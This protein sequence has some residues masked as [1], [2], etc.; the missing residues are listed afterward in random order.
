MNTR[1][2]RNRYRIICSALV[3]LAIGAG[4]HGTIVPAPVQAQ[5]IFDKLRQIISPSTNRGTATGRSRGGAIRGNCTADKDPSGFGYQLVALMPKTNL[6]TTVEANP[7]FW[8]YI[9]PFRYLPSNT[10][11][12]PQLIQVKAGEFMLLDDKGKP[13]LKRPIPVKLSDQAGFARFTLPKDPAFWVGSKSLEVGKR[14]NWFF[15][16]ACDND[17]PARNPTVSGWVQRV[18]QPRNLQQQLKQIAPRDRYTVYLQNDNWYESITA[19][20]DNRQT[21]SDAWLEL[22]KQLDLTKVANAPIS[23]MEPVKPR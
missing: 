19:L 13:M 17:Q 21:A 15:S 16:I 5:S 8:F 1:V 18:E 23:V 12:S 4:I 7:T 9:P 11:A 14:Y 6:G 3:S 10:S 2:S 22:L 20:A